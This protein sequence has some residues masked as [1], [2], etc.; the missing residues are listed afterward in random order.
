MTNSKDTGHSCVLQNVKNVFGVYKLPKSATE[1]E[2]TTIIK[3][4]ELN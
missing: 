2:Y 4:Y 3:E 1:E